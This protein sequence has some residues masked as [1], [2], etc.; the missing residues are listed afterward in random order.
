MVFD[1]KKT[2]ILLALIALGQL[3]AC[4]LCERG[5]S[6][7]DDRSNDSEAS[8]ESTEVT[9]NPL[10]ITRGCYVQC[11][12]TNVDS[13]T[14][15]IYSPHCQNIRLCIGDSIPDGTNTLQVYCAAAAFTGE[16]YENGITHEVVAGDHVSDGQRY[17]GY[18]CPRNTG[19]FVYYGGTHI[20][21]YKNYSAELDQAAKNGGM[22]F[23]QEMMIHQGAAV[24]TTRPLAN[25]NFFRALCEL[26]G[27]VC[28]IECQDVMKF[29]TFIDCLLSAGVTEA[30]YL[31]TGG[32]SYSW[33]RDFN[34]TLVRT[35]GGSKTHLSNAIVFEGQ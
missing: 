11:D 29:G 23:T 7:G 15:I 27:N 8:M 6:N 9:S 32:W 17:K 20:F 12:T 4:S 2:A 28:I 22:G 30:L 16:G 14:I 31:D 25:Q 34:G 21:L 1:M 35:V 19:A 26:N 33:Y 13:C 24:K 5:T 10:G 18:T 3:S